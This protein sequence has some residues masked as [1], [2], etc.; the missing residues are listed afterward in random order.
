V[1]EDNVEE[2][3]E[4]NKKIKFYRNSDL[5][6]PNKDFYLKKLLGSR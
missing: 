3:E 2:R 6:K 1:A 4:I 5:R